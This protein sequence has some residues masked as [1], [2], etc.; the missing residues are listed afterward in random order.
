[1]IK[2]RPLLGWGY[3]NYKRF[4]DVYYQRYPEVDTTAH[5]HNNLL[6]MW[7]DGGVIGLG[8]FLFLFWSILK[9]G[10]LAY[11]RLPAEDEPLRSL[12]LGG[13]LSIIGFLVGG[14]TQY[15]FG[16]AEVVLVMWAIVGVLIRVYTWATY[17]TFNRR[18]LGVD[19]FSEGK[20]EKQTLHSAENSPC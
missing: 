17:E 5:A 20:G 9:L 15:N 13:F 12:T 10:W 6:Q 8:A 19:S 1:M 3:G 18:T 2:E 16:D 11:Q 7:V 14:L 4:R